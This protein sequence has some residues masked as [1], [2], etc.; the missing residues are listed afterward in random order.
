MSLR[1]RLLL[2]A[3]YL[4]VLAI[5]AFEVPLAISLNRRVHSEVQSQARSQ[6]DVLAATASDLLA[7]EDRT[8]LQALAR[9]VAKLVRGRVVVVDAKARVLADSAGS[10]P[11]TSHST[12]P[13]S[14]R[15]SRAAPRN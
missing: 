8:S 5:L 12:G 9:K 2:G 3:G 10:E 11:P 1:T 4:L 6:T 15:R 13:R 14:P 7:P